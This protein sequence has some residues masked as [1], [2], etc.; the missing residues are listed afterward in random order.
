[1]RTCPNCSSRSIRYSHARSR[2]ELLRKQLLGGRFYRCQS[3]NWRGMGKPT[4]KKADL[5]AKL[6]PKVVF[7]I[8]FFAIV[9]V[10]VIVFFV[11]GVDGAP[12]PVFT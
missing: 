11:F 12:T 3:C 9:A 7:A 10:L 8:Y 2:F 6:T 1:M 4:N 5:N